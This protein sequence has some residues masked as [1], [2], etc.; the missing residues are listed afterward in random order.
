MR[1]LL[2]AAMLVLAGLGWWLWPATVVPPAAAAG[3][4]RPPALAEDADGEAPPVRELAAGGSA[5]PGE[6]VALPPTPFGLWFAVVDTAGSPIPGVPIEVFWERQDDQDGEDGQGRGIC[7]QEG[8]FGTPLRSAAAV[9]GVKVTLGRFGVA[10][11]VHTPQPVHERSDTVLLVAPGIA[12]LT[13][14][15][16]DAGGRPVVGAR[17]DVEHV[18]T[19]LEPGRNALQ[20]GTR[21]GESGAD[22]IATLSVPVGRA[23]VRVVAQG[24]H[25]DCSWLCEFHPGRNELRLEVDAYADWR[26]VPVTVWIAGELEGWPRY[27]AEVGEPRSR[28]PQPNVTAVVGERRWLYPRDVPRDDWE[29]ESGAPRP[30]REWVYAFRV[31]PGPWHLRLELPGA[32][33]FVRRIGADEAAVRVEFRPTEPPSLFT[34]RGTVLT[35]AGAPAA[36]AELYWHTLAERPSEHLAVRADARGRFTYVV[37]VGEGGWVAAWLGD[38]A[39]AIAGPWTGPGRTIDLTLRLQTP[40]QIQAQLVDADGNGVVGS[41]RLRIPAIPHWP[42]VVER[43]W[44]NQF[45]S[46]SRLP[47]GTYEV[48]AEPDHGGWPA[49]RL[50]SSGATVTLRCGEGLDDLARVAVRIVDAATLRPLPFAK[51]GERT[52]DEAGWLGLVG[53]P[54]AV[55]F[56]CEHPG[57]AT[58]RVRWPALRV[59]LH[60]RTI[61]LPLEQPRR[62]RLVDEHGRAMAHAELWVV[63]PSGP[64]GAYWPSS[65]DS[66][67]D[68]RA[69]LR[70]LPAGALRL[71]VGRFERIDG[72]LLDTGERREFELP[73]GVGV[74][75][76]AVLRWVDGRPR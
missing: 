43:C 68:G 35:A 56:D 9:Q 45:L 57:H 13:A 16:V 21:S 23:T 64:A 62:V 72:G 17:V 76:T 59:G 26:T 22:G 24:H 38:D 63:D 53:P 74:T 37:P 75:T 67:D 15:V 12:D 58:M 7:D 34:L 52:A 40:H 71:H 19:L 14:R 10:E 27:S 39:P 2:A 6:V 18:A 31:P 1:A 28:R 44:P 11:T 20:V 66:D 4:N 60:E 50:V 25:A 61:A 3:T 5:P 46:F 42:T 65:S 41:M 69:E 51:C 8:R 49:R 54:G 36:G 55:E 32:E 30:A 70:G 29:V 48:L 73:E 47:A 33:P